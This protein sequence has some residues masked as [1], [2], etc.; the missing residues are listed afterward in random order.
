MTSTNSTSNSGSQITTRLLG[1]IKLQV[2]NLLEKDEFS[3]YQESSG[4]FI[5]NL[6]GK[7]DEARKN[8]S[9][10]V[11]PIILLERDE[12]QNRESLKVQRRYLAI[13]IAGPVLAALYFMAAVPAR[14]SGVDIFAPRIRTSISVFWIEFGA[15]L[16][17]VVVVPVGSASAS[18]LPAARLAHEITVEIGRLT[19]IY[20]TR[21]ENYVS[22]EMRLAIP[23]LPELATK[24]AFLAYSSTLVEL[25]ASDPVST[26]AVNIVRDFVERHK[27][28]ALGL[29]GPR[30]SGKTTVLR[31]LT[32]MDDTLGVNV[33]APVRYEPDELL[34][35]VFE[36]VAKRFLDK[37]S[38]SYSRRTRERALEPPLK[39]LLWA[40]GILGPIAGG[41]GLYITGPHLPK[42]NMAR[43]LGVFLALSGLSAASFLIAKLTKNRRRRSD[44]Q[45]VESPSGKAESI[46]RR[47]R[48]REEHSSAISLGTKPWGGLFKFGHDRSDSETELEVGRARLVADFKDFVRM[49]VTQQRFKRIIV[50]IDELDKLA[51]VDD[52]IS[53][54]NELKD[55]LHIEGTHV[56]ISVSRDALYRFVLRGLPFRDVFDSAFD[57]IVEVP[58][59]NAKE[60]V[61]VLRKRVTGFP[62]NWGLACYILSGGLPRDLLR[63][64]RRCLAIYRESSIS[65]DEVPGRVVG[66]LVAERVLT[67]LQ[68]RGIYSRFTR[69]GR[70]KFRAAVNWAEQGKISD[71]AGIARQLIQPPHLPILRWLSWLEEVMSFV[72]AVPSAQSFAEA[73]LLASAGIMTPTLDSFDIAG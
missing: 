27:A 33:S 31:Y 19:R 41:V 36:K 37:Y 25:D 49:I 51:T 54:V 9:S 21:L 67:E 45:K 12:K 58:V 53:V 17:L 20:M 39:V 56:I 44:S 43:W 42:M 55:I 23:E 48:W 62:E 29:A 63:Y 5:G 57:E 69:T 32:S 47:L 4:E 68:A 73:D 3:F 38:A 26:E 72:S 52:L 34:T 22:E 15:V 7:V 6:E 16:F 70:E 14:Y 8:L 2:L 1:D 46:L 60:A 66:E 65:R 30:G 59:L 28:S 50:A 24:A 35:L 61:T 13:A 64:G 71:I 10:D 18:Y 11:E 40:Y